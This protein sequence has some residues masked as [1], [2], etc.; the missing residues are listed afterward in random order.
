MSHIPD[1]IIQSVFKCI[2]GLTGQE[3]TNTF[4]VVHVHS[5]AIYAK[6]CQLLE[7]GIT[8]TDIFENFSI[9]GAFAKTIM[10]ACPQEQA[11]SFFEDTSQI[12]IEN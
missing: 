3:A 5:F 1:R 11:K 2:V 9:L 6:L 12:I 10:K 8:F 4:R 7:I